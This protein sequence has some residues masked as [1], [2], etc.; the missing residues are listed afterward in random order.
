M[1]AHRSITAILFDPSLTGGKEEKIL[2]V[3]RFP[4]SGPEDLHITATDGARTIER[5]VPGGPGPSGI[6][7]PSGCWQL[8]LRWG[9]HED[10]LS[11]RYV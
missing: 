2:W 7:L 8:R 4:I 10:S 9:A 5:V 3:S 11:L 1:G 6:E